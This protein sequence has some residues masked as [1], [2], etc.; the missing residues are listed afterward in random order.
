MLAHGAVLRR[1]GFSVDQIKAILIDFRPAGLDEAEVDMMALGRG[2]S[3]DPHAVIQIEI[4][5][6]RDHGFTEAEIVD[7]ALT[8]AVRNFYARFFD[9]LGINPDAQLQDREP[10]L[11][12]FI[13]GFSGAGKAGV[14]G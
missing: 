11:W 9:A 3:L 14:P 8:A 1:N 12:E 5:K 4:Q 7:V 10:E 6:L 2:F 13:K